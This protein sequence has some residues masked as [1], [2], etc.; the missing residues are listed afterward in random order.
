[1]ALSSGDLLGPYEI[2]G[3]LGKGGMGEVYRA[4][5]VRLGREVALKVL[6]ESGANDAD[7]LRRFEREA[8]AVAALNHPN[9]LS[10]HDTGEYRGVPYAVT[11]LLEGEQQP[12]GRISEGGA[13]IH[14]LTGPIIPTVVAGIHAVHAVDAAGAVV[15]LGRVR[16]LR[17]PVFDPDDGIELGV[18]GR[19]DLAHLGA[20]RR[21]EVP[22]AGDEPGPAR[23]RAAGVRVI[24][25]FRVALSFTDG[26]HGVVATG[27][28]ESGQV[29]TG[30][31]VRARPDRG[32][33]RHLL[34]VSVGVPLQDL[35][36]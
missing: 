21:E 4:R 15:R 22:R 12:A 8:R 17:D 34:R 25:P 26:S 20:D 36:R 3:P 32:V 31:H 6:A 7:T 2:L 33:H 14:E 10:I 23:L 28:A 1:M 27:T 13:I 9:I 18:V 5:D 29:K 35:G 24:G 19:D 16:F 30:D 11:E